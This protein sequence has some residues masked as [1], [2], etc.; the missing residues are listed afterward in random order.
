M[1][2]SALKGGLKTR[3]CLVK[4]SAPGEL[5]QL[6]I[7]DLGLF[8]EVAYELLW[9]KNS[10]LSTSESGLPSESRRADFKRSSVM[11]PPS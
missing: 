9:V 4:A 1:D 11:K 10:I 7:A 6:L 8:L 3:I 2:A 5:C